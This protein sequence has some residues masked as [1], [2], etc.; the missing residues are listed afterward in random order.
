MHTGL[1]P[2][3]HFRITKSL[4]L[5]ADCSRPLEQQSWA[6]SGHRGSR[7]DASRRRLFFFSFL[8]G[9]ACVSSQPHSEV[10]KALFLQEHK[11]EGKGRKG[12]RPSFPSPLCSF[13]PGAQMGRKCRRLLLSCCR[14]NTC[15]E[16]HRQVHTSVMMS[17]LAY[18]SVGFLY[19]P[20][21]QTSL[22]CQYRT[23]IV[24][25]AV[26]FRRRQSPIAVS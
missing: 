11:G 8:S 25:A 5:I 6:A 20:T 12:R 15:S 21:S 26:P 7:H 24:C 17:R 4:L 18:C 10:S 23:P 2:L 19:A 9:H 1:T 3:E 22:S 14:N 13:V 16:H